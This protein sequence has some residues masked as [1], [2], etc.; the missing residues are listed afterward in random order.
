LHPNSKL[1][2]DYKNN[3][4]NVTVLC[5]NNHILETTYVRVKRGE[6]CQECL[7]KIN[8][9][10]SYIGEFVKT[11]FNG[12]CLSRNYVDCD[13]H[14]DFKCACGNEFKQTWWAIKNGEKNKWCHLCRDNVIPTIEFIK[15]YVKEKHDGYCLEEEYINSSTDMIFKCNKG[16][17]FINIWNRIKHCNNWCKECFNDEKIK[18]INEF[19]LKNYEGKLLSCKYKKTHLR[20]QCKNG[21]KFKSK[22]SYVKLHKR[23]CKY[24]G[25]S[26]IRKTL[27]E[28]N[29][30]VGEKYNGLC[31]SE[32]YK[33]QETDLLLCCENNHKF[34]R[35][36]REIKR[37]IWCNKCNFASG[38]DYCRKFFEEKYKKEFPK[39]RPKWLINENGNRLE[40][41]GYCEEL[42][43]AFEYNGRQHYE[44]VSKFKMTKEDLKI[45]KSHDEIKIKKCKEKSVILYVIPQFRGKFKKKNLESF[46]EKYDGIL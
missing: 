21:H 26:G 2:S 5:E 19:V 11:N 40:L 44:I 1:I 36:W 20:F 34:K 14:L 17:K 35:T 8:I 38:E 18:E 39:R 15:N 4:T 13:T 3:K 22:W 41:D 10:I 31:L 30:Y 33:N 12:E 29:E 24:C 43:L 42:N 46:I 28:V 25:G 32:E 37:E 45:I 6:W 16:H 7:G 27:K 9:S 23:W